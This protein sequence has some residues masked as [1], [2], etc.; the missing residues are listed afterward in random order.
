MGRR[1]DHS[2][3]DLFNL[4][5]EA[6]AD[7]LTVVGYRGL[8]MRAI[9][10]KI[11]YSV[12]TL[13]NL[14]ENF[15]GMVLFMNGRTLDGLDQALGNAPKTGL[16]EADLE[17]LLDAYLTFTNDRPELWDLLFEHRLGGSDTL[18]GWYQAK[19]DK[20]MGRLETALA[21]LFSGTGQYDLAGT[22]E[23]KRSAHILWAGLHGIWFL[24]RTGKLG[25]V[26][27]DPADDLARN[28]VETY[29]AGL[30]AKLGTTSDTP[31]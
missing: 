17:M 6:I 9:A 20:V 29:I 30:R 31:S 12:G 27:S 22:I 7:L 19:V 8:N 21:P 25:V 4:T 1:A 3:D 18:P 28:L 24:A 5:A 15:D 16:P 13:Y 26:T 14:F 10:A 2:R 11:G 23:K